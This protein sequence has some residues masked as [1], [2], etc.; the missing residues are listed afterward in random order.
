MS[1]TASPKALK[2][3]KNGARSPTKPTVSDAL[4]EAIKTLGTESLR[5]ELELLCHE[6][7]VIIQAL[8]SRLLVRGKD[9]V[10]YHVDSESED[11]T[12]SEVESEESDS[13]S[14]TSDELGLDRGSTKR[15]PISIGDEEYTARMVTCEN[16]NQEFDVTLN[17][18]GD[19][20]WHPG[21]ILL[22]FE[23]S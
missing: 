15:K 4:K 22:Y 11:D 7:P 1:G 17:Y 13:E 18:R 16:C 19:C 3:V 10:R 12:D 2:A 8:E 21:I 6:Y 23:H 9:V 5:K 14:D 20:E